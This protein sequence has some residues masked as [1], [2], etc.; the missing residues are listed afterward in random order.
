[1]GWLRVIGA[2]QEWALLL[3]LDLSVS[4]IYLVAGGVLWGL[5]GLPAA[6]GLWL[7]KSWAPWAARGA[8]VFFAASYWLDRLA[9]SQ[10]AIAQPNWPFALGVTLAGLGYAFT[11]LALGAG[12]SYFERAV[13]PASAGKAQTQLQPQGENVP[14]D[15]GGYERK[16]L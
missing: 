1:M 9:F 16:P 14:A 13:S 3:Q 7:G 12:R 6:V 2:A 5:A 10:P 8:A 11:I 4:P 15:A